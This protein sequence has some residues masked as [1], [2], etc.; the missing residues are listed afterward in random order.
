M[1]DTWNTGRADAS[2]SLSPYPTLTQ[3]SHLSPSHE[4]LPSGVSHLLPAFPASSSSLFLNGPLFSGET[5]VSSSVRRMAHF[6]S[7]HLDCR[8]LEIKATKKE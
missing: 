5:S 3:C 2:S 4:P 1:R 7:H 8:R 6:F